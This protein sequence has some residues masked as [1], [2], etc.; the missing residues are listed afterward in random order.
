MMPMQ[1]QPFNPMRNLARAAALRGG[2]MPQ[3]PGPMPPAPVGAPMQQGAPMPQQGMPQMPQRP[4]PGM[5]NVFGGA[6][7]GY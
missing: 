3:M 6:G 4:M 2:P 5:Q 1:P 7:G